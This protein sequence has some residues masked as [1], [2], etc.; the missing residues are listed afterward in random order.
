MFQDFSASIMF[1]TGRK[2]NENFISPISVGLLL[3][4]RGEEIVM[5]MT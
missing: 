1:K 2:K 3:P 4:S 5:E